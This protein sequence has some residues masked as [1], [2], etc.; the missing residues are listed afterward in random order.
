MIPARIEVFIEELVLHGFAPG[1][2]AHIGGTLESELTRL[3]S[4]RGLPPTL[5]HGSALARLDGGTIQ[6]ARGPRANAVGAQGAR[7]VYG[8]LAK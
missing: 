3:L 8:G 2:R 7:A 6:L 1:D 5:A 4:E